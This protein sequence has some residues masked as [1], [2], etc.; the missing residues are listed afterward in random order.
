MNNTK[1]KAILFLVLAVGAIFILE[2]GISNIPLRQGEPLAWSLPA[3]SLSFGLPLHFGGHSNL[4]LIL[5][6]IALLSIFLNK[7]GRKKFLYLILGVA[8]VTFILYRWNPRLPAPS[9]QPSSQGIPASGAQ[10]S[11]EE[12][13][14][15]PGPPPEVYQ[16]HTPGWLITVVGIGLSLMLASAV[17]ALL[18]ITLQFSIRGSQS[19]KRALA[20]EAQT[21][22]DALEAGSDL[23]DVISRCY[24]QMSRVLREER[25]LVREDD[26]TPRE[27]ELFLAQKGFP[28]EAVQTLTR[29]FEQVRYGRIQAGGRAVQMAVASLNSIRDHCQAL[30]LSESRADA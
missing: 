12:P 4:L 24:A 5:F 19:F 7:D 8:L 9:G 14:P 22:I 29:L 10:T 15:Y 16:P 23:N 1:R 13:A 6:V 25:G 3:I 20:E 28:A 27:F 21:A 11:P 26:M 17:A 2:A 18:W 30:K